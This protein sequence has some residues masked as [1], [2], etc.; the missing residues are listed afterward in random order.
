MAA[1]ISFTV[2]LPEEPVMPSTS[3]FTASRQAA[4]RVCSA[5]KVSATGRLPESAAQ[6]RRDTSAKAP[7]SNTAGTKSWASCLSPTKATNK[8]VPRSS[9]AAAWRLSVI[10]RRI[11]R[12][13][14]G[15][16]RFRAR[17]TKAKSSVGMG[18]PLKIL[19]GGRLPE[20]VLTLS[21]SPWQAQK[22]T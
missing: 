20:K 4:A 2:V 12:L 18:I 16:S 11:G 6:S 10:T 5:A 19:R 21:G 17:Q 15:A 3:G 7:C 22:A 1:S 13:C 14:C 8:S 9:A